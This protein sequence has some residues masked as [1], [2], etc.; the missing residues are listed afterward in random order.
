MPRHAAR[1]A[2]V[3]LVLFS[4][5]KIELADEATVPVLKHLDGVCH[6][7]IDEHADPEMAISIADN[8]KTQRYGTC[9]TMETLLV[10]ADVAA[11]FPLNGVIRCSL[12]ARVIARVAS[13]RV[14]TDVTTCSAESRPA[15]SSIAV[16]APTPASPAGAS[17]TRA[18]ARKTPKAARS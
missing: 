15:S 10:H 1:A 6:V 17:S 14:R 11:V 7:F 3:A 4:A 18:L 9:N 16:V 8:A 5:F 13:S 2:L 12:A